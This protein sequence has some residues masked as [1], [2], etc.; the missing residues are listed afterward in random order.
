META[1]R[2]T[3]RT[4]ATH[5]R[6]THPVESYY[7][8]SFPGNPTFSTPY[9]NNLVHFTIADDGTV[10]FHVD[11]IERIAQPDGGKFKGLKSRDVEAVP[12]LRTWG[13]RTRIESMFFV[14]EDTL[15]AMFPDYARP[16]TLGMFVDWVRRYFLPRLRQLGAPP[17]DTSN[18]TTTQGGTAL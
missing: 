8:K 14:R 7:G 10:W 5:P 12:M 6:F 3:A 2:P 9:G 18:S 17:N 13:T 15:L 1:S 16:S 11:D 4:R